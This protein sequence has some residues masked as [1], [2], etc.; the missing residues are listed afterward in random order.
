MKIINREISGWT[1]KLSLDDLF[2][3]TYNFVSRLRFRLLRY[4]K[5]YNVLNNYRVRNIHAG[6]RCFIVGNGPSIQKE[7][8]T[9]LKDEYTFFVNYFYRHDKIKDIDPKY[10]VIID[11]KIQ[12]GEWPLSMLSEITNDCPHTT[13]I[14]NAK[15]SNDPRFE[16]YLTNNEVIWIYADQVVHKGFSFPID[17]TRN[18]SGDNVVK[19]S[20]FSAIYMG[21]KDIYILGV[22]CDGIFQELAGLS[23]H[24]YDGVKEYDTFEKMERSL[25]QTALGFRGW[26][27]IADRFRDSYNIVNLTQGGLLNVFPRNS[28]Q[29]ILKKDDV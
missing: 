11:P 18:I 3:R 12:T 8:L 24:F 25:W 29:N 10:Y 5:K 22:D 20:L 14:L 21:F 1:I 28:L 17:L 26:Q 2:F 19:A 15:W 27:A 9:M 6:E 16:S 23:S 7:D 13:L 4:N